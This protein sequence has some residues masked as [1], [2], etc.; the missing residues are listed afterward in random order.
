MHVGVWGGGYEG[1]GGRITSAAA[2][3]SRGGARAVAG[4]KTANL[5][6]QVRVLA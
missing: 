6:G 2:D 3:S 1:E 4:P 5:R